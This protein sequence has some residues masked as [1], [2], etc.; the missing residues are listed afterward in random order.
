MPGILR[1]GEVTG[2][3]ELVRP[4]D[5]LFEAD[6]VVITRTEPGVGSWATTDAFPNGVVLI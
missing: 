4:H 2:N 3:P 5:L 6:R 1:I